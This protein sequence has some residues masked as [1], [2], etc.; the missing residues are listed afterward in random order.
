MAYWTV[1]GISLVNHTWNMLYICIYISIY[2]STCTSIYISIYLSIERETDRQADRQTERQR[3]KKGG[4]KGGKGERGE[5]YAQKYAQIYLPPLTLIILSGPF[6]QRYL[7]L[8]FL[9]DFSSLLRFSVF[10]LTN[11][12]FTLALFLQFPLSLIY[13]AP[14]VIIFCHRYCFSNLQSYMYISS[15]IVHIYTYMYTYV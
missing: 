6:W 4:R 11:T 8:F 14:H 3:E 1:H 5:V 7:V 10:D 13:I 15:P 2:I 12:F 9:Q